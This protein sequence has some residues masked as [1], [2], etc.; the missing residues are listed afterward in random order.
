MDGIGSSKHPTALA[1]LSSQLCCR[2]FKYASVREFESLLQTTSRTFSAQEVLNVYN[3]FVFSKGYAR[4]VA[5]VQ[6]GGGGDVTQATTGNCSAQAV[7]KCQKAEWIYPF[8]PEVSTSMSI[9]W[10]SLFQLNQ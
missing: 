8:Q 9:N 1:G 6:R 4:L 7:E 5:P 3:L 2:I 10:K